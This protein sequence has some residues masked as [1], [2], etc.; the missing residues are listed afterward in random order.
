MMPWRKIAGLSVC[1]SLMVGCTITTSDGGDAGSSWTE[2]GGTGSQGGAASTGGTTAAGGASTVIVCAPDKEVNNPCGQCLQTSDNIDAGGTG[3]CSD[4]LTCA[5]VSGC[6]EIV[7]AMAMCMAQTTLD[8]GSSTIAAGTDGDCR[9]RTTG[10]RAQDTSAAALA[11][12]TFWGLI[13]LN[14]LCAQA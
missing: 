3:M 12:Q 2:T 10:M 14:D 5:A 6:K 9:S 1:V 13:G 4:Y 11:A 8:A 7:S